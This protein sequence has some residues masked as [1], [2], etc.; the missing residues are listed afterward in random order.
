MKVK[1]E[2]KFA[3]DLSNIRD[4]KLLAK[5]KE[6]IIDC[7]TAQNLNELKNVKKLQGYDTNV[8]K[9]QGYDTFYRIRIGNYRVGLEVLN[10]ELIFTRFLHR[11]DV[12]KYF[13]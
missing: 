6:I 10:D 7:K 5:I 4:N 9:L 11:K 3:K 1:F 2:S 13:P 8:K 12:Y